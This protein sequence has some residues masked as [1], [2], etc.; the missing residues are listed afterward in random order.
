MQ[1]FFCSRP[2]QETQCSSESAQDSTGASNGVTAG[3]PVTLA[4]LNAQL[5]SLRSM[6]SDFGIRAVRAEGEDPRVSPVALLDSGATREQW[7]KTRGGTLV[8]PPAEVSGKSTADLQTIIPLGGL[9]ENLGCSISWSKRSGLRVHHPVHGLLKTG[10]GKNT[11][12]FIHEDQALKLISELE[13]RRLE[14][15]EEQIQN[16]Q[17]HLEELEKPMDPTE[18]LRTS[19]QTGSRQ[20]ALRAIM[21]RPSLI[22]LTCVR[23]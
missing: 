8:V 1:L 4:S 21:A 10:V 19:T 9:V 6:T 20:D 22:W 3:T 23:T 2:C 12:P 5:E 16:L 15:F 13:D 17:T 11:C 18:A 14:Q 7:W